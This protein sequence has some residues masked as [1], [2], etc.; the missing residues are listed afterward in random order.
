[1][2]SSLALPLLFGFSV[3]FAST[4]TMVPLQASIVPSD[5]ALSAQ[6]RTADRLLVRIQNRYGFTLT[7]AVARRAIAEQRSILGRTVRLEFDADDGTTFAP[8]T[9][10]AD[11]FV[12][13][14]VTPIGMHSTIDPGKI[15]AEIAD[16]SPLGIRLPEDAAL[17]STVRDDDGIWRAQTDGIAKGGYTY[18][19]D[20][21]AQAAHALENGAQTLQV[22]L[23]TTPG[24]MRND[25]L[26]ELGELTLLSSGRS[27]FAGSGEGRK[28]NVRKGLT[29]YIHNTM[30]EPRQE[31]SINAILRNVPIGEWEMAL[32]IFGGGILRP[33][34]GGGLCQVATTLYR[35]VLNAGFPVT[36]R[37]NHS[38]FVHYYEKY[39]VGIDSTIF[40][41]SAPDLRFIN[42]TDKPL[43]I[44]AYIEESEA[45]VNI[46]GSP[47]GRAVTM[48]GPYF[49]E[50]APEDFRVKGEKLT[51]RDIA[52][53]RE[54]AYA[55]GRTVEDT[56]LS[57]YKSIPRSAVQQYVD[58]LA[59][60]AGNV[61]TADLLRLH[62]AGTE[63]E[64]VAAGST[65]EMK[66]HVQ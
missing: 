31:F 59:T 17:L 19:A 33:V 43:L 5:V 18:D 51:S 7:E 25:S 15:G 65:L 32:G 27:D 55:D 64:S 29:K 30:V 38:L 36:Q 12:R 21:A 66:A 41:A 40:P 22:A 57:R 20:L 11:R 47:D 54:T 14:E 35:G 34:A 8:W 44:Q 23:R 24:V 3:A 28:S 13:V 48:T 50:N 10:S 16:G 62:A 6:D 26:E 61:H 4:A 52:W 49:A 39:G 60:V 53:V 2:R 42:D 1:M 46:Y 9:L 45:T 37:S 58:T 56:V 63:K